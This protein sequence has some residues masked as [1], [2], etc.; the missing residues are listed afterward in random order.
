VTPIL[1]TGWSTAF[2]SFAT[3]GLAAFKFGNGD[4]PIN[5]NRLIVFKHCKLVDF[6]LHCLDARP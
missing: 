3:R 2:A 5:G 4:L 1:L 6:H